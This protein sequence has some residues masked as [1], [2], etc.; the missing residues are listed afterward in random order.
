[1]GKLI[2]LVIVGTLGALV[3]GG[4]LKISEQITGKAV[5]VLLLN[6]DYFPIIKNWHMNEPVEFLLHVFVS[7]ILVMIL[8][9]IIGVAGVSVKVY[10]YVVLSIV[11]GFLLYFSTMLSDRTPT[12]DDVVAFSYWMI[13]HIIYGVVIG[14]L[15]YY[16]EVTQLSKSKTDK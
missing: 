3:L 16:I 4:F 14:S 9:W 12:L 8:Y 13:G 15:I 1:M 5:Y 6:V 7:I 2:K 11:T 10:P